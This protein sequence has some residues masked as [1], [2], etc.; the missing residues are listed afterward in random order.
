MSDDDGCFFNVM[1]RYRTDCVDSAVY[2]KLR[3]DQAALGINSTWISADTN[4]IKST[5]ID[6]ARFLTKVYTDQL[7]FADGDRGRLLSALRLSEPRDGIGSVFADTFNATGSNGNQ[8]ADAAI[9][10]SKRKLYVL[11]IL[12]EG[13]SRADVVMLAERIDGF[14][15][16]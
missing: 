16:R 5:A 7:S 11:V 15:Q 1:R 4:N 14:M 10:S 2:T 8:Y 13:V 3:Q 6:L 9:I 12:T